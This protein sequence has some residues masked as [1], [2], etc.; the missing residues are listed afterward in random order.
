MS[1]TSNPFDEA[2]GEDDDLSVNRFEGAG[3]A[4][5]GLTPTPLQQERADMA[6]AW[7]AI[8]TEEKTAALQ[9]DIAPKPPVATAVPTP[10]PLQASEL[11]PAEPA[12]LSFG[13]A[14]R[15]ARQ[16][17]LAQFE[18]RGKAYTTQ[19]KAEARATAQQPSGPTPPPSTA[20][21]PAE[22]QPRAPGAGTA[23][24]LARPQRLARIP[25]V[26]TADGQQ[27]PAHNLAEAM[28]ASRK[29]KQ[30]QP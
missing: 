2:D 11:P 30:L 7:D 1:I 25:T 22:T 8:D 15:Q 19:L 12:G 16:D 27:R 21:K 18:W 6:A 23:Q 9:D 14:F 4:S 10:T 17:G 13:Q 20:S 26:T 3:D 28:Q 29:L 5:Y 24:P